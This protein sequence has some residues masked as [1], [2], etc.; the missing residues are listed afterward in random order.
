MSRMARW[1][2]LS[3]LLLCW[4]VVQAQQPPELAQISAQLKAPAV[5]RGEF[6]QSKL[7]SGFT[8]PL[9]SSGRFVLARD[10]GVLW[11]TLQPFPSTIVLSQQQLL[12]RSD[13]GHTQVL[14]SAADSSATGAIHALLMALIIADFD[15]L[16][17]QFQIQPIAAERGWALQLTP[18]DALLQQ[19][20]SAVQLAGA[21]YVER[22]QLAEPNGDQTDIA[23]AQLSGEPAQLSAEEVALFE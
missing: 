22:V 16:G 7:I 23:F 3:A 19:V 14:I 6:T 5:L 17:A 15:Q 11:E 13:D 18:T 8:N 9:R 20:F 21:D 2:M 4:P 12:S 10:R 1:L